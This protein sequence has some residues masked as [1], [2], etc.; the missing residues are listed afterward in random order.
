[1]A[2]PI[3]KPTAALYV[4]CALVMVLGFPYHPGLRSPNEL[5]RLWQAR[6]LVDHKTLSINATLH[7]FGYVG[8]LSVKDGLYYP[9]KAPLI[10]FLAAPIYWGL[11]QVSEKPVPDIPQVFFSRLFITLLPTLGVL[12]FVRRFLLAYVK[13]LTADAVTAA[14]ALG[15]M[16]VSYA[17]MFVSHQV[18]ANLLFMAF[19]AWWRTQRGDWR[20]RGYVACGAFAG[21]AVAAEY[22]AALTVVALAA[23]ATAHVFMGQGPGAQKAKGLGGVALRVS[24]GAL[25]FLAALMAYHQACFGNPLHSGYKYLADTAYQEWHV[26]GFLGIRYPDPKAFVLSFFSPLRGLFAL[27]PFL[28]LGVLGLRATWARDRSVA[29]LVGLLWLGNAYFT[30]SFQYESWGWTVGPRHLTPLVPFLLLPAALWLEQVAKRRD[31]REEALTAAASGALLVSSVLV[32]GL[33]GFLNYV[34]DSATTSLF[35]IFVPL[36]RHGD[37][38]V[39]WLAFLGLANPWSGGLLLS[40]LGAA[41]ALLCWHVAVLSAPANKRSFALAMLAVVGLHLGLL[42]GATRGGD[43]DHGAAAHLKS[44]WLAPSGVVPVFWNASP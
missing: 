20:S 39:S 44:V 12:F 24:L 1:M 23:A 17:Q 5:C 13:P 38:P 21:A 11:R 18:T 25:P 40:L 4:V 10:S 33:V 26:G 6:S 9:S 8:D 3:P 36:L 28:L 34:P 14:Y 43:A 7:E 41:V 16:A 42:A 19:Y 32:S 37:W 29:V 2:E 35:G 22:T 31:T 15:T 27:S 30:S